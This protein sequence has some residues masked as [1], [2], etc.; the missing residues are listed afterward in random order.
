[1]RKRF[2]GLGG[3]T[4]QGAESAALDLDFALMKHLL[5]LI[6]AVQTPLLGQRC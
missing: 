3:G 6:G 1:M 4:A 2:G 5:E